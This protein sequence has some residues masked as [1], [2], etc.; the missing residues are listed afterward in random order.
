MPKTA[1]LL[2]GMSTPRLETQNVNA[3]SLKV[4]MWK[5]KHLWQVV[6]RVLLTQGAPRGVA[7]NE[8]AEDP[9]LI[10]G[11]PN[12]VM[13]SCLHCS[14]RALVPPLPGFLW[15]EILWE[16]E[17]SREAVWTVHRL[18]LVERQ[19]R[20][21]ELPLLSLR[22]EHTSFSLNFLIWKMGVMIT[23]PSWKNTA[24]RKREKINAKP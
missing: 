10:T 6:H 9:A 15:T 5:Q 16:V 18:E 22:L 4:T 7:E 11:L 2:L 24:M 12:S 8:A 1:V 20:P 17:H 23:M 19:D 21:G 14:H 3:P 13:W